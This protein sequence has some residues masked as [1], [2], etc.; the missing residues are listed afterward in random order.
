LAIQTG[1]DRR[2]TSIEVSASRV[3]GVGTALNATCLERLIRP[4]PELR[5]SRDSVI[6]FSVARA[7]E[8]LSSIYEDHLS[9]LDGLV[10][11]ALPDRESE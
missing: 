1:T 4:D 6:G 9:D 5:T 8:D 7:L 11:E 3:R 2:E 10:V